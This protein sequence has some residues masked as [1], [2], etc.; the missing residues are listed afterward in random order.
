M[1]LETGNLFDSIPENINEEIF[2]EILHRE[3]LRV[4]RIIS[5]GHS[6]PADGWFDQSENEWVMVLKGE[7]KIFM[8]GDHHV[9]LK[10]GGHLTIPAHTKHKVTWTKPGTETVWLAIHYR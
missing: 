5:H 2:T 7:A 4:E 6:S 1:P 10:P 9:H 8:Q 3:N